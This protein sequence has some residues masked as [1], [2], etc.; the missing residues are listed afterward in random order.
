MD[1][2]GQTFR[3]CEPRPWVSVGGG[4]G[5]RSL[6]PRPEGQPGWQSQRSR[7]W[8]LAPQGEQKLPG[9][10]LQDRA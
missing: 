2:S 5:G 7:L 1:A 6:T 3:G 4:G 10:W 9:V 8:L